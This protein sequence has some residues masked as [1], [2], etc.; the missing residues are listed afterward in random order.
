MSEQS[1]KF[2]WIKLKRNFWDD[3]Y[4]KL[5]RRMAGGDTYVII[6]LKLLVA[7]AE[8]DG[9]IYYQGAG[10]DLAEEL[11]ITF[12]ESIED[13]RA[14]LA[15]LHAKKLILTSDTTG[16]L[17]LVASADMTGHETDSAQRVRKFRQRQQQQALQC[18][19][20]VT[21]SND[22]LEKELEKELEIEKDIL[23]GKPN[24]SSAKA[25]NVPYSEIIN[26]L[27]EKTSKKFKSSSQ[28][29][30]RLIKARFNEGYNL[31]D[32]KTAIDN[33]CAGWLNDAN[34]SQYL[35]PATLFGTKFDSY[36][37]DT[38]KTNRREEIWYE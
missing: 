19:T 30:K 17:F 14:L 18:N 9:Y 10:Q 38:P 25:D 5:L 4:I 21:M 3:P 35:R 12:D 31:D 8:T 36:L 7:S 28:A 13:V 32:F 2:F 22:K 20:H 34:M 24:N 33:K 6:Y 11:A 29:T 1:K 37:N 16:D 26:Y 23:S 27:N 15:Y